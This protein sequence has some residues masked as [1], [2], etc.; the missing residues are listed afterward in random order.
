MDIKRYFL[1]LILCAAMGTLANTHNVAPAKEV[2]WQTY[3]NR[4]YAFLI[5]HKASYADAKRACR[6]LNA[7]LV[8]VRS[9]EHNDFIVQKGFSLDL[10]KTKDL[11]QF[12]LGVNDQHKEGVFIWDLSQQQM[13]PRLDENHYTN[14]GST[15][16]GSQPN[17]FFKNNEDEDCVVLRQ[18]GDWYDIGCTTRHAYPICEK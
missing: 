3:K 4:Q 10:P 1:S 7:Q 9:Q 6:T 17:N 12:W 5:T 11:Q 15:T 18:N 13:W 2:P 16:K 8:Q 14:W